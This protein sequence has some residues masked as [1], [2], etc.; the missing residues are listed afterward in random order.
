[1]MY[2]LFG[3]GLINDVAFRGEFSMSDTAS[4]TSIPVLAEPRTGGQLLVDAL[5]THGVTT[6]YCLPGESYLA[7]L[8]ALYDIKAIKN[9]ICRHEGA[10][11]NMAEAYGKLTGEPGICFVTRGPGATHASVG[12]H[13][14]FQD[15]TPMIL[16][17]GQVA[18]DCMEREAFQEIDYRRMFGP[19]AKWVAEIESAARVPEYIARAFSTAT[20][21]RPGPV[22]LALPED[23][24]RELATVPDA[25]HYS[26]SQAAPRPADIAELKQR[27][28]SA[29]KPLII[30]GGGTWTEQ[31]RDDMRAFAERNDLPV[32]AAFRFQSMID[33]TSANYIG[34]VGLGI[35]PKLAA[36]IHES[37][38]V[39]AVGPRLGESTTGGYALFD[40]PKPKQ[41]LVHIH[42]SAEE[43]GRVYQ[44]DL[45]INSG[46]EPF[47]EALRHVTLASKPTRATWLEEGR[48]DYLRHS[49]PGPIRGEGVDM[50]HVVHHLSK[51]LPPDAIVTNGAGN[52]TVWIHRYY[53]HRGFRTQL[54]PTSGAMGY[55]IPAGI[56]AKIQHPDRVVVAFGGDGCFLMYGQELATAAQYHVPLIVIVVNNGMYGTIRFH[57]ENQYPGRVSG[58]ML[59]NPDFA[60]FARSFGVYGA[61]VTKTED[62]PAAFD[63]ALTT[64][65]PALLELRTDPNVITPSTTF[66]ELRA[67][68]EAAKK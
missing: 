62:F 39:V 54:A 57:Q 7:V 11:A 18:R 1:M 36:R 25:P 5:V 60:A 43:L 47:A 34:D 68:Q 28:E 48:A 56:A 51:T 21:G 19:M 22:V 24:L 6:T 38:L 12:V 53:R 42:A 31:A 4:T 9:I 52:Y 17:V 66:T 14:A 13:T 63:A 46:M 67:K 10:A 35:N 8:D 3:G 29:A 61:V 27:L 26:A 49:T 33:N 37:D 50:A 32:A 55:G 20:S 65:G 40:I 64:G 30:L 41:S 2:D 58:T 15:S 45:A 23:M 59:A 16:F 44:A